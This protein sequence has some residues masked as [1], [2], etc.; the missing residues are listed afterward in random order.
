MLEILLFV[1]STWILWRMVLGAE[2]S[3]IWLMWMW[4]GLLVEISC[5]ILLEF[6]VFIFWRG[7][8]GFG[9]ASW[10]KDDIGCWLWCGQEGGSGWWCWLWWRWFCRSVVVEGRKEKKSGKWVQT[11]AAGAGAEAGA[12][13][14]VRSALIDFPIEMHLTGEIHVGVSGFLLDFNYL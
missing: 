11:A 5:R 2:C 8:R 14:T 7:G 3:G 4:D 12:Q 10:L 6:A 9:L 1:R 13:W